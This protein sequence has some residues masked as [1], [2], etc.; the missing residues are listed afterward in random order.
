MST[1]QILLLILVFVYIVNSMYFAISGRILSNKD[2]KT[3]AEYAAAQFQ[4]EDQVKVLTTRIGE[5]SS[6][7]HRLN[8]VIREWMTACDN[9]K[10]ENEKL[11]KELNE[12][13][14]KSE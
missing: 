14:A 11:K 12:L 5:V 8:N 13:Q 6:E 3:E 2:R 1:F 9:Y 7:N 4:W 10:I